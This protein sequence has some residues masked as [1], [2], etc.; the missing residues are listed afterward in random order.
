MSTNYISYVKGNCVNTKLCKIKQWTPKYFWSCQ[1]ARIFP[2]GKWECG[3]E[4]NDGEFESP[5][6]HS[7][8]LD[9]HFQIFHLGE[10]TSKHTLIFLTWMKYQAYC[11]TQ[12]HVSRQKRC[13]LWQTAYI[14]IH[15]KWDRK[16]VYQCAKFVW[17]HTMC[18]KL[19]L[20]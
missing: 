16:G 10:I 8:F 7:Y 19:N 17:F 6:A 14:M 2:A 1:A 15:P 4:D 9:W 11:Y 5:A 13:L 12:K 3:W 20:L 18:V